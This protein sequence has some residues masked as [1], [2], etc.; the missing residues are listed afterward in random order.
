MRRSRQASHKDIAS[1]PGAR[2]GV[3][4][5][6]QLCEPGDLRAASTAMLDVPSRGEIPSIFH[7]KTAELVVALSGG[8]RA[9]VG[10]RLFH[11]KRGSVLF[12]PPGVP[13]DLKAGP[14]GFKALTVLSP[15]MDH[16]DPDVFFSDSGRH[17]FDPKKVAHARK[18]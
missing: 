9:K 4:T 10:A 13:H 5:I 1:I 7:R 17:I 12:I 14:S 15:F 8:A 2:F 18:E 11:L 16:G 3:S 6:T